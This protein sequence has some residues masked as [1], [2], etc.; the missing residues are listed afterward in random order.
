MLEIHPFNATGSSLF[1][2]KWGLEKDFG[3]NCPILYDH[4]M[5]GSVRYANLKL[6]N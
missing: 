5:N 3:G 1:L 2:N 6:L 4:H